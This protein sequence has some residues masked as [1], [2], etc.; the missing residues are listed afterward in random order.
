MVRI[1]STWKEC[2]KY[3]IRIIHHH[4]STHHKRVH[5]HPTIRARREIPTRPLHDQTRRRT[6]HHTLHEKHERDTR[7]RNNQQLFTIMKT[8]L[9]LLISALALLSA[10]QC[11]RSDE[12]KGNYTLNITYVNY[13]NR[14]QCLSDCIW[15]SQNM[16]CE[17]YE[18]EDCVCRVYNCT[19]K[20]PA[21]TRLC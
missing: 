8:K 9:I 18:M 21:F 10:C 6:Q 19:K 2:G 15:D 17:R 4:N 11:D 16:Q 5:P 7:P 13:S 14:L 12:Q 20:T 3:E 1:L